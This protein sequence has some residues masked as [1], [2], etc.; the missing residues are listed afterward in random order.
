MKA[1][2]ALEEEERCLSMNKLRKDVNSQTHVMESALAT[3]GSQIK[4]HEE[5][6]HAY[7]VD[8]GR[9]FNRVNERLNITEKDMNRV[10]ESMEKFKPLVTAIA[11]QMQS[12][13]KTQNKLEKSV[14]QEQHKL[15][16]LQVSLSLR[17]TFK[18][19]FLYTGGILC[20]VERCIRQL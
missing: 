7:E 16:N 18:G 3:V 5:D 12:H 8:T 10:S 15:K 13:T 14:R 11:S 20:N 19:L 17:L 6:M 1:A 9:S 2:V 4:S